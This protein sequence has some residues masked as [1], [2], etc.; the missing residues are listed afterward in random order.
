MM[1][2]TVVRNM[3]A[4]I[5]TRDCSRCHLLTRWLALIALAAV[6]ATCWAAC[7]ASAQSVA[8][9]NYNPIGGGTVNGS[10]NVAVTCDVG[11]LYTIS[12]SSGSGTYADRTMTNGG[13]SLVYNLYV[14]VT[15]LILWGDGSSGTSTVAGT[16]TG[17]LIN[18]PVY[19]RV[20]SGQF[21][22]AGNYTDSIV[23]TVSF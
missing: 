6:N 9:G 21:V 19:G 12:L 22:P 20:P 10:G 17:L 3:C 16:G 1:R 8:F 4:Q 14:D 2:P 23:V 11:T 5:G 18:T 13:N 7:T 15:R